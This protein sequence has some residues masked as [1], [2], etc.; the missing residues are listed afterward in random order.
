MVEEILSFPFVPH[1]AFHLASRL[2]KATLHG[3]LEKMTLT[4]KQFYI[5]GC[6]EHDKK[7]ID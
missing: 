6:V 2:L 3:W 7:K 1:Q 4:Q 5:E